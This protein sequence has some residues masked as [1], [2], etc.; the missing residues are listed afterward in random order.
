MLKECIAAQ[1][2]E[3]RR[4]DATVKDLQSKLASAGDVEKE[5]RAEISHRES[6]HAMALK[7]LQRM[8]DS[9]ESAKRA[10][11]TETKD[12]K[13]KSAE[14]LS[15]AHR[16]AEQAMKDVNAAKDGLAQRLA[17][18]G[19]VLEEKTKGLKQAQ[20][21]LAEAKTRLKDADTAWQALR[22]QYQTAAEESAADLSAMQ[23]QLR[24]A[25]KTHAGE[26]SAAKNSIASLTKDLKSAQDALAALQEKATTVALQS[27][28]NDSER[29]LPDV[30]AQLSASTQSAE[31][32]KRKVQD[33]ITT[34]KARIG[35]LESTLAA[36]RQ[37]AEVD[38]QVVQKASGAAEARLR[39]LYAQL[40]ALGG[41][42]TEHGILL[43]LAESDLT[44][45][46][47]QAALPPGGAPSLQR[48]AELLIQHPELNGHI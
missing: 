29:T 26:M 7:A 21:E 31:Q 33:Q 12:A 36:V 3:L 15:A 27:Q 2:A 9:S 19:Q 43:R 48:I 22:L 6:Q 16:E 44:F 10:L 13:A 45:T 24:A 30:K 11:Q 47:S 20:N 42:Q 28:L 46:P 34:A 23:K 25:E 39:D 5:L 17:E 14:A 35:E 38:R 1:K 41:R 18:A 40:I 8:L 4:T 32:E 37:Q